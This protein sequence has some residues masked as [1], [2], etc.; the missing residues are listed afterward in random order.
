MK[1][2]GIALHN[3]ASEKGNFGV[4]LEYQ[5]LEMDGKQHYGRSLVPDPARLH[6][7]GRP[8][9]QVQF[10]GRLGHAA[11]LPL[12]DQ[13][14]DILICPSVLRERAKGPCDYAVPIAWDSTA[15]TSVGLSG[16]ENRQKKGR[17]LLAPPVADGWSPPPNFTGTYPPP[18]PRG[19]R[20]QDGLRHHGPVEDTGRP[21]DCVPAG[22][23]ASN[24]SAR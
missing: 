14:I 18:H 9:G 7:P 1:Q 8:G 16:T 6:G 24:G 17:E 23:S 11:N 21:I 13:K 15:S 2:M 12:G 19:R 3:R 5:G 22:S 10:P 20:E 4:G